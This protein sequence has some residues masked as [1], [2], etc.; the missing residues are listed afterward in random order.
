MIRRCKDEG[1][2]TSAI[3]L[4]GEASGPE[5]VIH[6]RPFVGRS[7]GRL[8]VWWRVFGLERAHFY[9][10]NLL[11]YKPDDIAKVPVDE[12]LAATRN[13]FRRLALVTG[14]DD[15][16][17][18][19]IVPTGNYALYALTGRGKVSWHRRDGKL[20][21]PGIM[22]WRGSILETAV[23]WCLET[24]SIS[25]VPCR[26]G[27][28]PIKVIG[29][30]HPAH[31]LRNLAFERRS[32]IDWARIAEEAQTYDLILPQRY[33][34]IKPDVDDVEDFVT[35]ALAA[36]LPLAIDVETP[37]GKVTEYQMLDGTWRQKVKKKHQ[38]LVLRFKSGKRKGELK[39]RLKKGQAYL[40]CVGFAYDI[41]HSITIPMTL[42]YWKNAAV[43][44]KVRALVQHLLSS[45]LEKVMQN[46]MY[47]AGWFRLEGFT[48]CGWLW[49]TRVMH[50]VIDPRDDHD[51]A[52]MASTITRQRFWKH[53][54]KDP[55]DITKYA[56]NSEALWTYNGIDVCVTLEIFYRL[57]ERLQAE[58]ML[59]FYLRMCASRFPVLLDMLMH[60]VAVDDKRRARELSKLDQE[61]A[62]IQADTIELASMSLIAKKGLSND[63]L[64]FLFYGAR[65]FEGVKAAAKVEKLHQQWPNAVPFD[66]PPIYN[67]NQR[68]GRSITVDEVAI[69]RLIL[70]KP[71]LAEL[72]PKLLRYRENRKMAEFLDSKALDD[73]LRMRCQYSLCTEAARLASS[74]TPWG[75]GRN[76]QNIDR[77][78]RYAFV[79]DTD[80]DEEVSH[81]MA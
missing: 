74:K 44:A 13:L 61:A 50:W 64:K 15:R 16:G 9:I 47:D 78:L 63:R 6:G 67:R 25:P 37:R 72:G 23:H 18:V 29:T 27:A 53:E 73:D 40:G 69:R 34:H 26:C 41:N 71:E 48:I 20:E 3:V 7:G 70:K 75:K 46:G 4:C 68:G 66:F 42:S 54:A 39:T 56:T 36:G 10:T 77:R 8:S 51:L 24:D 43:L 30:I 59:Q 14:P 32:L 22:D 28:Q 58:H 79:P 35:N 57:L 2:L 21:R 60:G 55:E 76:L 45:D 62:D 11:D 1:A 31:V 80:P 17:P 65:G 81:G 49:D 38:H 5:E 19:V 52:Y 12:M 33:H